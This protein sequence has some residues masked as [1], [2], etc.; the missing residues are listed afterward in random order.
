MEYPDLYQF[1]EGHP[2][3]PYEEPIMVL[4]VGDVYLPA[5]LDLFAVG[6]LEKPGFT[7]GKVPKAAVKA[8]VAAYPDKIVPDGTRGWHTC[9]LC[10]VEMVRVKWKGN[11]FDLSGHGHYLV[12]DGQA[13]YMAPALLLHY[14]LDHDYCPPQLFIDAVINGDF[15]TIDDLEARPSSD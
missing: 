9:T 15:L 5:G 11:K 14:I 10:E 8:L 1:P 2:P 7:T 13:V 3:S 12:R 4:G 6:W